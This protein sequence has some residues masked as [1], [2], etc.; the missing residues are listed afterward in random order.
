MRKWIEIAGLIIAP[1]LAFFIA[2]SPAHAIDLAVHSTS[3]PVIVTGMVSQGLVIRTLDP[4]TSVVT[5]APA[6][7]VDYVPWAGSGK[8]MTAAPVLDAQG[9]VTTPAAF[10]TGCVMLVRLSGP[11]AASDAIANPVDGE[12]WSRSKLVQK[13]KTTGSA[14]TFSIGACTV[15]YVMVGS[16]QIAR[17]ADLT[18]CLTSLGLP[19]HEWAGGNS[20]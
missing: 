5:D 10:L 9:N 19:G 15:N 20:P 1:L 17:F 12:Q 7:G 11:M 18:A 13:I 8:L 3:C 16:F 6:P 14:G 4:V 2:T